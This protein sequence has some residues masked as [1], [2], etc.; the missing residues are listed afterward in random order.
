ML[1]NPTAKLVWKKRHY[2]L[3]LPEILKHE[4]IEKQTLAKIKTTSDLRNPLDHDIKIS[5]VKL[6]IKHN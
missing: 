1:P 3:F 4:S 5:S 6:N 2:K